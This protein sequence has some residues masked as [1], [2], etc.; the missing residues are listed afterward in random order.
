MINLPDNGAWL[1]LFDS[2][3]IPLLIDSAGVRSSFHH[4][5]IR[6]EDGI[7]LERKNPFAIGK[8]SHQWTSAPWKI[9]NGSPGLRN[10]NTGNDNLGSDS[11]LF[12]IQP[13][14]IN[15]LN[16]FDA[17]SLRTISDDPETVAFLDILTEW[18]SPVLSLLDNDLIG[19]GWTGSWDGF[20]LNGEILP[21]GNYILRLQTL[22]PAGARKVSV[23]T[24][25]L[26]Y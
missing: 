17:F 15:P 20:G 5:L 21:S 25:A 14:W 9:S 18:G 19:L 11:V 3:G 24:V 8:S 13:V 26:R 12:S 23:K 16:G 2:S 1:G 7:A 10:L 6:V 22:S 4:P